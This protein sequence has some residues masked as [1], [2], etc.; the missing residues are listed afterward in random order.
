MLVITA[1]VISIT[2]RAVAAAAD[3]H[4]REFQ[5]LCAVYK[6]KAA[7]IP[8]PDTAVTKGFDELI[9]PI[10]NLNISVADDGFVK[11]ANGDYKKLIASG[12]DE[13]KLTAW[14]KKVKEVLET[15]E[16]PGN[17]QIY[18][19]LTKETQRPQAQA[20]V[21]HALSEAQA[22]KTKYNEALEALQNLQQQV[23]AKVN[24]AIEGK[25]AGE[26]VDTVYGSNRNANGPTASGN[27]AA[28][29]SVKTDLI[30]L[31]TNNAGADA[32][33]CGGNN[34][35]QV[36]GSEPNTASTAVTAV[37]G[38]CPKPRKGLTL[39]AELITATLSSFH[40]LL[41]TQPGAQTGAE[42]AYILGKYS[43]TGCTGARE[44][45]CINYAAH[46]GDG[47]PGIP[48]EQ[49]LLAAATLLTNAEK[50]MRAILVYQ[51]QMA[52]L[53]ATA[54]AAYEAAK[55]APTAPTSAAPI[56]APV[57]TKAETD[58]TCEKKGVDKCD[59]PCKVVEG[60]GGNKKCTLDKEESRRAEENQAGKDGKN[61]EKCAGKPQGD[62]ESP[63]CKWEGTECKDSSILVKNKL[64]VMA[65]SFMNMIEF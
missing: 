54:R 6:I 36:T 25:A 63:E 29:T 58:T 13:E 56:A 33:E 11:D 59:K 46:L 35:P 34:L 27:S 61:E 15:K 4:A 43:S 41:G 47:K 42:I 45:N 19:R 7:T 28:G 21:M 1:V 48:W 2:A 23:T 18:A 26:F 60:E 3:D 31:C 9:K 49:A 64:A 50:Q 32:K 65:A 30:S 52:S 57:V 62:C 53:T 16:Q 40:S 39:T 14:E 22:L 12:T 38:R 44:K 8:A 51:A 55:A 17:K 20:T 37:T 5:A 10:A 24:Q